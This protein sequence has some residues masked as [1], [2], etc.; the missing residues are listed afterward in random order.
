M[1]VDGTAAGYHN[2]LFLSYAL[3]SG[4]GDAVTGISSRKEFSTPNTDSSLFGDMQI[5]GGF[6]AD[7]GDHHASGLQIF[8]IGWGVDFTK[9]LNFSATGH[10]FL[11][12]HVE[13]NFSRNIGLEADFALTY[14]L[15]DNLSIIA[16][17]DHFFTGRFFRDAAMD[18]SDIHYGYMMLE[19]DISHM[20]PKFAAQ[21]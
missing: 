11:A 4:A 17:Y 12:N 15:N 8:T 7:L 13:E 21:K 18:R 6:G 20:K 10:Y 5:I 1:S 19:F 2:H 3:G 16:G 9:E 14:A